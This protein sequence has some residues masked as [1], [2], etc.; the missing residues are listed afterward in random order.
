MDQFLWDHRDFL[1]VF[2]SG[3]EG[4]V[5][6]STGTVEAPSNAKNTL[7]VGTTMSYQQPAAS[8]ASNSS[9]SSSG[10]TTPS[11]LPFYIR[12]VALD[13]T[14][15]TLF[16]RVV[17]SYEGLDFGGIQALLGTP[18]PVVTASPY[19]A[20]VPLDNPGAVAGKVAVVLR[21]GTNCY[22]YVKAGNVQAAGALAALVANNQPGLFTPGYNPSNYTLPMSSIT[23]TDG[24]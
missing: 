5:V 8:S 17:Q 9:G 4:D 14:N 18:W 10:S 3:N 1:S 12:F 21:G 16:S 2:A 23:Q 15:L 22:F 24:K 19:Q 20:C 7:A 13:V 11:S 6:S